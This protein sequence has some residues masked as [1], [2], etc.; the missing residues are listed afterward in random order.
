MAAVKIAPDDIIWVA[1]N[2]VGDADYERRL[3][4][5]ATDCAARVLPLFEAE[6]P[7]D[8][9]PR[10]A[11]EAARAYARGEIDVAAGDAAWAAA[12]DAEKEQ[13]L[14]LLLARFSEVEPP[15]WQPRQAEVA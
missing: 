12:R 6:H 4:L 7:D 13:Q 5:F 1:A 11:I 9:R 15:D 3:R 14:Q 2:H 8:Q 10:R